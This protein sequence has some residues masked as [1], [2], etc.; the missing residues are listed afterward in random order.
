ME[1]KMASF[2]EQ[3]NKRLSG[4]GFDLKAV[5]VTFDKESQVNACMAGCPRSE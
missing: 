1:K 2:M 4:S 5:F 3:A